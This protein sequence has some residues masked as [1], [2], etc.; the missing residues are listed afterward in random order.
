[1]LN[2]LTK[3][4][5][6]VPIS[7]LDSLS[8]DLSISTVSNGGRRRASNQRRLAMAAS[9]VR[10][11][12]VACDGGERATMVRRVSLQL[13]HPQ[14]LLRPHAHRLTKQKAMTDSHRLCVRQSSDKVLWKCIG[15]TLPFTDP[16]FELKIYF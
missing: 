5:S 15:L 13:S 14:V 11:Q 16:S 1:M 6:K 12:R 3:T 7:S 8:L 10:R 4:L 9:S 2:L